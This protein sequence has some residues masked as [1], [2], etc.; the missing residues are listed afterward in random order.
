V[1]FNSF[2]VCAN[3]DMR[4]IT[5]IEET[6]KVINNSDLIEDNK[7][8]TPYIKGNNELTTI[9]LLPL[10]AEKVFVEHDINKDMDT[11]LK[12]FYPDANNAQ[13]RILGS[14][15]K[16]V[17]FVKKKYDNLVKQAEHEAMANKVFPPDANI[18]AKDGEFISKDDTPENKT[19]SE[20][21]AVSNNLFKYLEYD[22]GELGEP[23]RLRDKNYEPR[24]NFDDIAV[25]LL[26]F[27]IIGVIK[28]L[29]KMPAINDGSA[30]KP[31]ITKQGLKA[32]ILLDTSSIADKK[33]FIST[34]GFGDGC[35][36]IFSRV[37]N[38]NTIAIE[39]VFIDN[40]K[41]DE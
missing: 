25:A 1:F 39:V 16:L 32:R 40:N 19:S 15:V 5:K 31:F 34:S 9:L 12:L 10:I 17:L 26:K 20:E 22:N 27:D 7:K 33:S 13:L 30:E 28:A 38:G 41:N 3:D 23:V 8:N 18:V 2:G 4:L 37:R 29:R 35:Y 36:D 6:Y 14:V 11:F 24:A 21:Y